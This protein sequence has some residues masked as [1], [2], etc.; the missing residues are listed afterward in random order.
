MTSRD[1]AEKEKNALR[2]ANE[3]P[4]P[5]VS[6]EARRSVYLTLSTWW[7]L[8]LVSLLIPFMNYFLTP[9]FFVLGIIN[10]TRI[11]NTRWDTR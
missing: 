7:G 5:T 10:A 6:P 1:R 2:V 11:W 4:Y 9:V 3:P 8:A